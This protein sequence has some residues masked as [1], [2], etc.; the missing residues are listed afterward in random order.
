MESADNDCKTATEGYMLQNAKER[1]ERKKMS[2]A[3][4]WIYNNLF[5]QSPVDGH[6]ETFFPQ[7]LSIR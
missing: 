1:N 7:F 4:L 6:L 2:G 3:I 5:I